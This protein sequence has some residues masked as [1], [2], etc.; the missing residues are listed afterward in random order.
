[1]QVT[2]FFDF[3]SP[4]AYLCHRV[5]P[6]IE[7]RTGAEFLYQPVLLGGIFKLTGNQSPATAFGHI[8]NKPEY[9]LSKTNYLDSQNWEEVKP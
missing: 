6:G 7:A 4:N 8:K 3:G 9:D 2:F 5:I 1:M